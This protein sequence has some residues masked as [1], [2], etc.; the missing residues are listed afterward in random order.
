MRPVGLSRA[1]LVRALMASRRGTLSR[2]VRHASSGAE[3]ADSSSAGIGPYFF[4]GLTG[5]TA[6][7]GVW[8]LVRYQGKVGMVENRSKSLD[9]PLVDISAGVASDARFA[10]VPS[11]SFHRVCVQGKFEAAST[12]RLAPRS[13]PPDMPRHLSGSSSANGAGYG[14]VTPLTRS[15]GSHVLVFRG[16]VPA[17]TAPPTPPA[18]TVKVSGVVRASEPGNAFSHRELSTSRDGMPQLSLLDKEQAARAVGLGAEESKRVLLVEAVEPF[19]DKDSKAPW[20][21]TRQWADLSG[22]TITPSTH[23]VYAA[24]WLTLA[25]C[26]GLITTKRFGK[27]T[28]VAGGVARRGGRKYV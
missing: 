24:T 1:F 15:D 26:A 23:L 22:S 13:P 27:A 7:L 28:Q 17:E 5:L 18:G 21:V 9:E 3:S 11:D 4:M 19:P 14:L 16:W 25:A 10:D 20:P 6:G 8:Q 12:V 2:P